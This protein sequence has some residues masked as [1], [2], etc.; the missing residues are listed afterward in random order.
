MNIKQYLS[1]N[2]LSYICVPQVST[3]CPCSGCWVVA[4][5][6]STFFV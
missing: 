5:K 1:Q 4:D 6:C 2:S 3:L